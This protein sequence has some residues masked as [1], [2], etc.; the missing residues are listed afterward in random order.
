VPSSQ[1]LPR[2]RRASFAVRLQSDADGRP[3]Y[4]P[5]R[6]RHADGRRDFFEWDGERLSL[7]DDSDEAGA[8]DA[9]TEREGG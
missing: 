9:P 6:L 4:F 5:I 2:A 7:V 3:G 8:G 1:H